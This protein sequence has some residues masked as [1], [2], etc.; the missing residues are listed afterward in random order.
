[1]DTQL[2]NVP[3][4][5]EVEMKAI[6]DDLHTQLA[7]GTRESSLWKTYPMSPNLWLVVNQY[8]TTLNGPLRYNYFSHNHTFVLQISSRY[9][10]VLRRSF[11]RVIVKKLYRLCRA[12]GVRTFARRILAT[13][14][15]QSKAETPSG[16]DSHQPDIYFTHVSPPR[17]GVCVEITF[18]GK[19]DSIQDLAEF[20][21]LHSRRKVSLFISLDYDRRRSWA[22][23]LRTWRRDYTDPTGLGLIY[24]TQEIRDDS[25]LIV[26]GEPL[27][28]C[29]LDFAEQ[30]HV[31]PFLHHREIELSVRELGSVLEQADFGDDL[32]DNHEESSSDDDEGTPD[33]ESEWPFET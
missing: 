12:Y 1:M 29:V 32:E 14:P 28:I 17:S 11:L 7:E 5:L 33:S 6:V 3:L 24:R 26:A 8:L 25:G 20:Y 30:E 4:D 16:C 9:H 2:I 18:A 19:R 23:T 10:D 27:K 13:C 15:P 22:V 31:P 21:I